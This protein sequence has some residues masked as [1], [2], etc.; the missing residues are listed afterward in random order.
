MTQ[1]VLGTLHDSPA[2]ILAQ[3]CLD[4]GWASLPTS[5]STWPISVDSELA[6]PD[7]VMTLTNTEGMTSGRIQL[8]GQISELYG[9]QLKI[10]AATSTEAFLQAHEMAV[11]F[12]QKLYRYTTTINTNSYR[13]GAV[14]RKGAPLALGREGSA[15]K[16]YLYTI[17]VIVDIIQLS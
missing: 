17:N 14:T 8:T 7:N 5:L 16:R 2:A 1:P 3:V 12:D 11:N 10:R 9:A 15:T 13:I 4:K 6:F